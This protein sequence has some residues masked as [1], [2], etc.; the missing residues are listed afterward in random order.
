MQAASDAIKSATSPRA[1]LPPLSISDLPPYSLGPLQEH[2]DSA[3]SSPLSSALSPQSAISPT[4]SDAAPQSSN[5]SAKTGNPIIRRAISCGSLPVAEG[6]QRR[7]RS[8]VTPEQLAKLEELFAMDN[9]P[10]SARRKDIARQLGMDE[11]QTQIWFQNRRAKAKLQLKLQARAVEKLEPPPE[12]PPELASGFD[13]DIHGLIHEDAD[14]TVFPCTDLTIGTWRRMASPR[15]DL[16]AYTCDAKRS[17]TWFIRSAGRSFKMEISYEHIAEARFSNVSP[18]VGSATF[19]LDCPPTFYMEALADPALGEQS[20]RIWQCSGDW[21]EAMQGTT[22]L[23]H[24][25][26]GP[27]YQLSALVNSIV[28]AGSISSEAPLYP[29]TPSVSDAGSSPE[30]YTRSLHSPAEQMYHRSSLVLRRPSSLSSLRMLHHPSLERLRLRHPSIPLFHS[31]LSSTSTPNS[32]YATSDGSMP[33][34]PT[35]L[36]LD[37]P[38]GRQYHV[39]QSATATPDQLTRLPLAMPNLPR[40]QCEYPPDSRPDSP[41]E[42]GPEPPASAV[43][44]QGYFEASPINPPNSQGRGNPGYAGPPG[45]P[46]SYSGAYVPQDPTLEEGPQEPYYQYH[47]SYPG[48]APSTETYDAGPGGYESRNY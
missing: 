25:L 24:C 47:T 36:Y 35:I 41:Y 46:Y 38:E 39:R 10:T 18:G 7:K 15:H 21:T 42:C 1:A 37:G 12:S 3:A 11:R 34:S 17:L 48:P 27:A 16:I 9:S 33:M 22:H 26:V 4:P 20:P 2:P 19:I 43:S 32:P 6:K 31:P 45:G 29:P 14:V 23:Q 28:P 30:V 5:A 8:R 44:S 13:V 40:L